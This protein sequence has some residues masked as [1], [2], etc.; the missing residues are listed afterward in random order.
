MMTPCDDHEDDDLGL[1]SCI[2]CR[3]VEAFHQ[4]V[5]DELHEL[6]HDQNELFQ[7][8]II[9]THHESEISGTDGEPM[10]AYDWFCLNGLDFERYYLHLCRRATVESIAFISHRL[11]EGGIAPDRMLDHLTT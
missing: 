1:E 8:L 2:K 11:E 7:E 10:A 9:E 4:A 3:F 5:L 6:M